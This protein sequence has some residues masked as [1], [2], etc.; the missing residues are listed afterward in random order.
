MTRP[1]KSAE[2]LLVEDNEDDVFLTKMAFEDSQFDSE[3]HVVND[4]EEALDY[5]FGRGAHTGRPMPDLVLLDLNL[6]K[7]NGIEI[8]EALKADETLSVIPVVMLTS[9]K[10][11][12]DVLSSY[13]HHASGYVTKPSEFS[14]LVDIVESIRDFWFSTVILPRSVGIA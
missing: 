13:R 4:G 10:A 12:R 1:G 8:L 2:I 6:P 7:L 11:E 14:G 5:L 9:S 3:L